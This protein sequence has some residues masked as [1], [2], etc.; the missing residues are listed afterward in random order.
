MVS[1]RRPKRCVINRLFRRFSGFCLTSWRFRTAPPKVRPILG[2]RRRVA[3]VE[4]FLTWPPAQSRYDELAFQN[5]GACVSRSR[6]VSFVNSDLHYVSR[7][8]HPA[9]ILTGAVVDLDSN[10]LVMPSNAEPRNCSTSA[11]DIGRANRYRRGHQAEQRQRKYDSL[12]LHP[13]NVWGLCACM[14]NPG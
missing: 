2:L 9:G 8:F 13:P 4:P 7:W 5:T 11:A 14:G 1:D 6:F 10:C 3:K 12:H